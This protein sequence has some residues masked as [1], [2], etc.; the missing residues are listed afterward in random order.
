MPE[1]LTPGERAD[2]VEL[3]KS[4]IRIPSSQ[5]DGDEVYRFVRD[6]TN[7][8]GLPMEFQSMRSPHVEYQGFSNLFVRLGGGGDGDS[9]RI[10]LNG[11]LDTVAAREGWFH[12]PYSATE[13][14]GR[15][16]GLGAA[17]MKGGCAA[18]ISAVLALLA[19]RPEPRGELLLT[20]VYGEEAP[21][22][23]G[24][25]TILREFDLSGFD[26]I[27][28]TEPSPL[29]AVNDYCVVHRRM[30]RE[31]PF[32]VVIVGAEGRV[33]FELEL[34]GVSAHASH[35]SQGINALHDAARL[36]TALAD[37][38]M[39]SSIKMGRGHYVVLGIDGGGMS[40]TVPSHCRIMVNRQ[41]TIGEDE[42]T[43]VE[44]LERVL[45]ALHLRSKVRLSKRHSPD[46]GVEYRPYL[47]ES[48]PLIDRFIRML[49]PPEGGGDRCRM[50]SSSVGD[51]NLYA[52]RT[53]VP[54][55]VF[56]P[57]GGNI[58]APNE[59][60][61]RDEVVATA[62]HLLGFLLATL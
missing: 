25:D 37:F 9:K 42:A 46:P 14:E 55:L 27:L 43:V 12:D 4:L 7:D 44:E 48:S 35:P 40:F 28:V 11:H 49:G 24:A 60:V 10:M 20:L 62:D 54:T 53:G 59:Y 45:A 15:I 33:M 29:L 6:Y 50:T 3:T 36:I 32:P 5:E 30:H 22:S 16:Y 39:Y 52:T 58:H 21:Y 17:D 2:L 38:D 23:L 31:P 19:R 34:T 56:G 8:R 47:F 18:A 26:L 61:N 1:G 51:N 57:G 13:E 41:L